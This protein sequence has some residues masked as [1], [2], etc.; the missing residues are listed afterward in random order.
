M[1]Q[2]QLTCKGDDE[3]KALDFDGE[4]LAIGKLLGN[5]LGL[6]DSGDGDCL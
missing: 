3:G 1:Q 2:C 4:E 6:L 5:V